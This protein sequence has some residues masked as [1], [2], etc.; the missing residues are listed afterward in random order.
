M[1]IRTKC[2]AAPSKGPSAG[3]SA[4]LLAALIAAIVGFAGSPTSATAQGAF[5]DESGTLPRGTTYQIRVPTVWN[6]TLINDLDFA[7]T[8]DAPRY[9]HW[10]GRGY[11]VSGT[12][13]RADRATNYDPAHEIHD[14]V[15]VLDLFEAKY[16][17]PKRTIQYGHSGG[18]HVALAMAEFRSDRIDGAVAGCAHTPVWL[19]NSE[20]DFW[21]AMKALIAPDLPIVDLPQNV[22]ALTVQWRAAINEAQKT[23][24]GRAR[25][26]LAT[27]IGQQPAWVSTTTPEPNANDEYAL[28]QSMYES[29]IQRAG[30]QLGGQSRFMFEHAAP[31]QQSWNTGVDYEDSFKNGEP[32]YKRAVRR[33]YR[34]AGVDF[35][36]DIRKIN[37]F[38]RV[39]AD[40]KAIKWWSAPGRTVYGEPKVPVFRMHTNGDAAVTINLVEGYDR[41]VAKNGYTK[42]YRRAFV[43]GPGH[44][45]FNVSES[46][47]AVETLMKR[48]DT[49]HWGST[50]SLDLNVLG[51]ALDPMSPARYYDFEQTRY[52]RTWFPSVKEFIGPS[53]L[54][55]VQ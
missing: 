1:R 46:A 39:A 55:A 19:Q 2:Y 47:A 4:W 8:P 26:A 44:C 16:G 32:A 13:R 6:G 42:L 36:R 33:L 27:T 34:D 14:L 43:N 20:L 22:S 53:P 41:A 28:Q 37:A 17:K 3:I 29:V 51:N 21:F 11:A 38:P 24:L 52:N 25:I 23:A 49:G 40:P 9:L 35:E 31:G 54:H 12:A 15:T 5:S 18:G 7:Q 50:H 48:L 10:L 45:A 30:G